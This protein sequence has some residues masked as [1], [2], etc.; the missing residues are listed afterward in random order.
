MMT[1]PVFAGAPV[2]WKL[3][4]A[5]LGT[6]DARNVTITDALPGSA[7]FASADAPCTEAA[8]TVTCE[9]G[10]LAPGQ[11][12]EKTITAD[13]DP[14][15]TGTLSNT[16]TVGSSTADPTPANN[17]STAETPVVPR[18]DLSIMKE[19]APDPIVPGTPAT[20]TLTITNNGPS[21]ATGVSVS[22]PMPTGLTATSATPTLGE[23]SVA[24]N[25]TCAVGTL[26]VG[27]T[28]TIIIQADVASNVTSSITNTASV[29]GT[30]ADPDASDDADT[31]TTP[32]APSADLK[33]V[34][35]GSPNPVIAG[36]NIIYDLT[37]TN[38]GP[39]DSQA[40][41]IVDTLP[42]AF[43]YVSATPTVGSCSQSAA[44]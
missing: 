37:V 43:T 32:V 29:T 44:P 39:S 19:A 18:S 4:V 1:T 14:A 42:G 9:L 30:N 15:F 40:V 36:A 12:I 17:T 41:Q 6:S 8:G 3:T 13:L 10:T 22:D 34:K 7:T 20:Y 11:S 16:A 23:C 31:T 35:V 26:P 27:A 38:N 21:T 25:V 28:A 24:A 2:T 33:I 5:N